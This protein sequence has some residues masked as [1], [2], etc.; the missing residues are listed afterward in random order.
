[1]REKL[2]QLEKEGKKLK[3]QQEKERLRGLL[4]EKKDNIFKLKEYRKVIIVGD[5]IIKHLPPLEGVEVYAFPG[6][7]IGRLQHLIN[8]MRIPLHQFNYVIFHVGTNNIGK[9]FSVSHMCS[10]MVNL[11]SQCRKI[12][13]RIHII[14]SSILP[15]P[16]DN[17]ITDERIKFNA[18]VE[19]VLSVDLGV[20]FIKSYRP[21]CFKGEIKR[22]LFARLDGGLHLNNEGS[23]RLGHFFHRFISTL[24]Y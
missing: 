17:E 23:N 21:F 15:R 14:I 6:A 24:N 13:P 9:G 3:K 5:S 8:T 4:E 12:S 7:T 11:I 19:K 2:A 10:D 20:K 1:M 16:V 22:Y 18:K